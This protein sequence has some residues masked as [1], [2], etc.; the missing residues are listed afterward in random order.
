M[1]RFLLSVLIQLNPSLSTIL[2]LSHFLNKY[3]A[4]MVHA[5][6]KSTNTAKVCFPTLHSLYYSRHL[7]I[8]FKLP[9]FYIFL[10]SCGRSH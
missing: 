6:F 1:I 5:I 2:Y 9:E 3:I 4:I 7:E 8:F 10:M